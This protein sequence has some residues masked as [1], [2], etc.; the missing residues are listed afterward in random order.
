[1]NQFIQAFHTTYATDAYRYLGSHIENHEKPNDVTFRVYAPHAQAISV[2]G[3]FNGWNIHLHPM[4]LL[5]HGIWEITI[6]NLRKFTNYKYAITRNNRTSL[7]QDPYAYH[8]ETNGKTSSKVYPLGPYPYANEVVHEDLYHRPMNIYEVHLSSWKR[9][10]DGNYYS[11][12]DLARELIP[13]A[14]EMGYTHLELMPIME[15]PFDGS[16]GYQ[17]TGYYGITSR[18]GTPDDFRYFVHKAHQAGLGLILDWVPAHFAKDEFGLIEYDGEVLYEDPE[19]TRMEHAGWGTRI[20]NFASPVV[21]SFLISSALFYFEAY[22]ID[23]LRVDAVASMLYL[24]Y[25]RKV[26]KPNK[27][28]NNLNLEAIT[29]LKQLNQ[30]V[31]NRFPHALM[32]AE[33]ST[34]FAGIT[35]PVTEGGLGFHLKW[36]MGWMNDTLKYMTTDPLFRSGEHNKLTFSLVYAFNEHFVLPLSHDEVV[37][38]K[39]S[40]INKM[41]GEYEE[42]FRQLKLLYG[43]MMTHPGKKL[44]FMGN[45]FAQF[46]EWNYNQ[47]LD[48]LLMLYPK[49]ISHHNF[50]KT[51]NHLYLKNSAL[52]ENDDNWEGFSWIQ[53][54]QNDNLVAYTRSSKSK[55]LLIVLN[56][57]GLDYHDYRFGIERGSYELLLNS[58]DV[59]FGGEGKIIPQP[60]WE[61]TPCDGKNSSLRINIPRQSVLILKMK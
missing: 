15:Y 24:D 36:N 6:P 56:F 45:E 47:G 23:G 37:H 20:F 26:W 61:N 1:M 25:D 29:F 12:R 40:L 19:P 57:S 49:H 5:T 60:H 31:R 54:K 52:W 13:Y 41:P 3:D 46:I 55:K 14:K 50:I 59:A 30:E 10:D 22:H 9:H 43:Y 38:G 4:R 21:K 2:V 18:F 28:G 51:L 27:D 48:W 32:I 16:W 39:K 53:S 34:S 33:E 42:K 44:S 35:K 58:D 7:K 11:Y 17:V 8:F